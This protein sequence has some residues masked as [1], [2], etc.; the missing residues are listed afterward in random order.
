MQP[1]DSELIEC[2][3]VNDAAI[4]EG[5]EFALREIDIDQLFG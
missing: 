1:G 4:Q 3:R 5:K 2:L